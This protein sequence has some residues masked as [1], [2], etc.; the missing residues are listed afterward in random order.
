MVQASQSQLPVEEGV[1][2]AEVASPARMPISLFLPQSYEV[3]YAYPLLVFLH[4]YGETPAQWMDVFPTISRRNHIGLALRGPIVV[5]RGEDALGFSWGQSRRC[6][7]ALE[8]YV[9][10]AIQQTM[11]RFHVHSER[12][13]LAGICEGAEVAYHLGLSFPE[14]FAGVVAINGRLPRSPLP[15][16]PRD[17]RRRLSVFIGHGQGNRRLGVEH[18]RR[19]EAVLS[20]VGLDVD[21]RIYPVGHTLHPM[22]L[23]DVD[24]WVIRRC[25]EAVD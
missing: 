8:D 3:R 11:R 17:A 13:F 2:H 22:M 6:E 16:A 18:A 19:A 7:S 1:Y 24:R 5:R 9:F 21:A 25:E 10:A 20:S 12:I 23:R 4:G 14:K 15:P